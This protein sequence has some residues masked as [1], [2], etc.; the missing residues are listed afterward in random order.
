MIEINHLCKSFGALEVLKDISLTVK[1]GEIY[2][3]VGRSGA[4]KSTLL[5]CINGLENYDSGSLKI[6]GTEIRDL[7][8][9]EI[10]ELRKG[11]GMIFQQFSLIE[12]RSVYQNVALP[13]KCWK[14]D[15]DR[16][17]KRVHEL[18]EL[19]DIADKIND[20]PSVLS[21]GQKQ[22]VAI[23][24]ALALDS[25]LLLCDEA[26]SALDPKTT[27]SVLR[28]LRDINQKLGLTIIVVTHQMEVVREVCDTISILENGKIAASGT[29]KDIFLQKPPSLMTLLG[30]EDHRLASAGE[31]VSFLLP[32]DRL[33]MIPM[34]A[35]TFGAD[36]LSTNT[37]DYK[38]VPFTE[39]TV[40]IKERS[41]AGKMKQILTQENLAWYAESEA[42]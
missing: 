17:D 14:Y 12:R 42:C 21:G 34:V 2:G 7:S 24:R 32:A 20:R 3:L 5:R 28:L 22:R 38:G 18:L 16:I 33:N 13:M 36:I 9:Q 41:A 31:M 26:T 10:R 39:V 40:S 11:I 23:A 8:K 30:K 29:V 19:V 35:N 1:T 4:G 25:N 15:K 37:S 6:D 27:Q